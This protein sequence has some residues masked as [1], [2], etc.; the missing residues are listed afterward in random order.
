MRIMATMRI[1]RVMLAMMVGLA[2]GGCHGWAWPHFKKKLPEPQGP[3]V[4]KKSYGPASIVV[5]P[6]TGW[7]A[8]PALVGTPVYVNT[9]ELITQLPEALAHTLIIQRNG[10]NNPDVGYLNGQ[11]K[12][13]MDA[14]LYVAVQTRGSGPLTVPESAF[15]GFFS[16][17]W[18][19]VDGTFAISE[20]ENISPV[21][22][23]TFRVWY[24]PIPAGAVTMMSD[25]VPAGG[26]F[27]IGK[28][29]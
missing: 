6:Y 15:T 28:A 25:A 14:T 27:F 26:I 13:P 18:R 24:H 20:P 17:G 19:E 16:E 2:V 3:V 29:R 7:G 4:T 8:A 12:V 11:V 9:D 23:R 5:N 1:G 22:R 10:A 21:A